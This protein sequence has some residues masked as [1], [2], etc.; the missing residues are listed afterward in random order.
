MGD[1]SVLRLATL[2][3]DLGQELASLSR[4]SDV[5]EA[6]CV[7]SLRVLPGAAAASVTRGLRGRFETVG[8]TAPLAAAG[9]QIQYE[10]GIG[11]C[12]DAAQTDRVFRANEIAT[13]DRWPEFGRRVSG[14]GVRSILSFRLFIE[15]TDV[16][17][18]L[19]LYATVPDAFSDYDE[20]VGDVL[21]THGAIAMTSALAR[22]R[23][24][25]LE[26]ALRTNRD[27]GAAMGIL[28][29]QYKLTRDQAFDIL[30]VI[31]QTS[32]RKVIAVATELIETGTLADLEGRRPVGTP[33]GS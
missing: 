7:T 30:R 15:D 16:I 6:F 3:A 8:S 17:A 20:E 5:F 24:E 26:A 19:N 10:L 2:F 14:L 25:H 21:C 32:N 33:L 23:V 27:I 22:E 13:D 31:S 18:A 28:M 9:D 11:P 29:S 1:S 4:T 12:V